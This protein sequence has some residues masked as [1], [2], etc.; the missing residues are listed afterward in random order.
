DEPADSVAYYYLPAPVKVP[1]DAARHAGVVERTRKSLCDARFAESAA[2]LPAGLRARATNIVGTQ[3]RAAHGI[4]VAAAE[5][6]AGFIAVGARGLG[7]LR[8]LLVGSVSQRL[9]AESNLPL[10]IARGH[11]PRA[12]EGLRVLLA[13]ASSTVCGS[14][15]RF[16]HQLHWH[17]ESR[18]TALTVVESSFGG[19]LPDW[20][21]QQARSDETEQLARAWVEDHRRE[22]AAQR[23]SLAA[24]CQELPQPF[25]QLEPQV[26]EGHPA[27]SILKTAAATGS[28]LLVLGTHHAA[29][30]VRLLLGSTA[31]KV[32]AHAPCSVLLLPHHETP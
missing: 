24:L 20:L 6:Q 25:R 3:A 19:E 27:E 21:V 26:V 1:A 18:G 9:A 2:A 30:L 4:L 7:P 8:G 10:L 12:G 16:L 17:P 28:D 29:P 32:L 22:V 23:E 14:A 13:C 31:V 11:I 15:A 5:C